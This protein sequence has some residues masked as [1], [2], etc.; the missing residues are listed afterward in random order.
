MAKPMWKRFLLP[1][2]ITAT[3]ALALAFALIMLVDPLGV[4]PGGLDG[5][6]AG[7][8]FALNDR[9]F[10]A[11][12]IVRSEDYDSF[13]LGTSTMH[14]VD[15]QWAED[16][17]GGSF[18]NVT[19]HGG[20]PFEITEMIRLIAHSVAH[21]RRLILGIDTKRWCSA[22]GHAQRRTEV[23]FPDWLYDEN[24]VNDL[25]ALLN[26]KTVEA[27]YE[28]LEVEIGVEPPRLPPDGYRNELLDSNWSA[29]K[30]RE[31]I[32][33]S[34]GVALAALDPYGPEDLA[35][36]DVP[37][38]KFPDIEMLKQAAAELP[39]GTELIL[40]ITPSNVAAFL[41][42]SAEERENVEQCK[43]SLASEILHPK[44]TV[45][46]FRIPSV[47][48]RN[49]D[50]YWDQGHIRV[51]LAHDL[52]RRLKE[53]VERRRDAADG[54]YRYLAGPAAANDTNSGGSRR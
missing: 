36:D 30:A 18:A 49:D 3:A 28:Q 31:K 32:H 33:G 34:K 4:F 9:R 21:P 1:F 45:I 15:P 40:A 25:P 46:D 44:V 5:D 54:V 39:A 13:I 12:V 16:A 24:R 6:A 51:G 2:A 50:N 11:P 20:T 8:G 23:V 17:F 41:D 27:A 47:W 35:V 43:R 7:P 37:D 14:S 10:A 48:T 22:N 19:L 52:V 38:R 29:A 53:A 42:D 26:M